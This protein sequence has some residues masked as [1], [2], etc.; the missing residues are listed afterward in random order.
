MT[1]DALEY[2]TSRASERQVFDHLVRCDGRYNPPLSQRVD[3]AEYA[4][5]LR[6]RAETLEAWHDGELVGVVAI[7]IDGASAKAF[8]SSVS[9]DDAFAGRGIASRLVGDAIALARSRG[10]GAI[11]LEVSPQSSR[12]IQLYEK[13]GFRATNDSPDTLHMQLSLSEQAR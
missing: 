6:T 5:K 13:Y 1:G 10:T 12:A 3:I 9:V 2:A 4:R 7:Y 11:S 8:V